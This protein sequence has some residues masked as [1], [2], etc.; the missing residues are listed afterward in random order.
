MAAQHEHAPSEALGN[1]ATSGH[2]FEQLEALAN[3]NT[4]LGAV[5]DKISDPDEDAQAA[6]ELRFRRM[7]RKKPDK[8]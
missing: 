1:A 5:L 3:P 4:P 8:K 7:L 2:I 6:L